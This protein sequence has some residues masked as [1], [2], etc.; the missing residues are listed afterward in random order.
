M[1]DP[2]LALLAAAGSPQPDPAAQPPLRRVWVLGGGGRLGSTVVEQ[3][4]ASRRF[5]S[6]GVAI[7]RPVAPALRG[8]QPVIDDAAALAA[9]RADVAVIVFDGERHANGRDEAFVR[10]RPDELVRRARA[11]HDLGVRHLLVAVPHATAQLPQALRVGLASLDE[12]AVAALGFDQ[13]AFMRLAQSAG[14]RLTIAGAPQRLAH[15]MLG[16]LH[17]MV[18]SSEQP[19]RAETVARVVRAVLAGWSSALPATR[20]LPPALLGHAAQGADVDALVERWLAGEPLPP[21]RAPRQRW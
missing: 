3:L 17:W 11:L 9:F 13:L 15:W 20:V 8:L 19:V 16:Q 14:G 2:N 4:L 18:P 7:R 10:P 12:A 5:E 1:L 21:I 6:V